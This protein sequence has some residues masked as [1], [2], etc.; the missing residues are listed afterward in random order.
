VQL[1]VLR[2]NRHR[3]FLD[4][5]AILVLRQRELDA[6][7]VTFFEQAL[8]ARLSLRDKLRFE[9]VQFY[10]LL[11]SNK[12]KGFTKLFAQLI[13]V[14]CRQQ[15]SR[16]FDLNRVLLH[17][18]EERLDFSF[19]SEA[20]S[21]VP[22]QFKSLSSLAEIR[23]FDFQLVWECADSIDGLQCKRQNA[24]ASDVQATTHN[25]CVADDA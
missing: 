20:V 25:D 23:L 8:N 1:K 16:V 4:V 15:F 21:C 17:L 24:Q 5:M 22:E 11:S 7:D 10:I 2:L 9:G 19:D 6:C 3:H 12:S 14:I 13:Q 18:C